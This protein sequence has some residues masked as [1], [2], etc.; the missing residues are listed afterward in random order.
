MATHPALLSCNLIGSSGETARSCPM[1]SADEQNRKCTP[2]KTG[3][4][5]SEDSYSVEVSGN[6]FGKTPERLFFGR[7]LKNFKNQPK[8]LGINLNKFYED[9]FLENCRQIRGISSLWP[10]INCSSTELLMSYRK[11]S[12]QLSGRDLTSSVRSSKLQA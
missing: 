11:I 7:I 8:S 4:T 9:N 5:F 3:L 6:V 12:A 1:D 2:T 10:L